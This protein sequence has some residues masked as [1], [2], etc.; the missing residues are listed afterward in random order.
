MSGRLHPF[1]HLFSPLRINGV[2]VKNR[3]VMGPMGNLS[4]AHETGRPSERM[5]RYFA[6]RAQGGAGLLTS[7]LVP[8]SQGIDPTVTERGDLSYFPRLDRS[9]SVFAGWRDVATAC[10]AFGARFF[11][12]LTAGLGRVGSPECL[13]AKRRLPVSASWNPNFYLPTVPCRPLL[14][15]ELR[16]I[17]RATGQA[18]ADARAMQIDGVYL[19]GHE[20][21]L[22]DQL[23]NPAFNRRRRGRYADWQRFGLD[24]VREVRKRTDERYPIMY[25]IDL[26][27]ALEATY[28]K[29]L[30]ST[31]SL[32]RFTGE[33]TIEMSLDYMVHL[34]EAGVDVF[35]V[36]LGCY[37][38]WWLPHP[39]T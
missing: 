36:D 28:G 21:Y 18:A 34:V 4:V 39:P 15:H 23:T 35:D 26:T 22:L 16:R 1:E 29:R 32:R 9:R 7:G 13:L 19:H 12:Q 30:R 3:I 6:E 31:A 27:S 11:V 5:V 14:D 2:T 25:R 17:V 33:R 37:D 20:G 10:H 38:N 24:L 8:V